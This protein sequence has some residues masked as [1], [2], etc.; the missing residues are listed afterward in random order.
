MPVS[1][2]AKFLWQDLCECNHISLH[3]RAYKHGKLD[4]PRKSMLAALITTKHGGTY[5]SIRAKAKVASTISLR[6]SAYSP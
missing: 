3:G 5:A 4:D 1:R 6:G 2:A